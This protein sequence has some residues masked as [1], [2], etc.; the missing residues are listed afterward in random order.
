MPGRSTRH[1]D[2]DAP[3]LTPPGD[4]NESYP[5]ASSPARHLPCDGGVT[6]PLFL[7]V[8]TTPR[9]ALGD[10]IGDGLSVH[11]NRLVV[12]IRVKVCARKNASTGGTRAGS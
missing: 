6:L 3:E 7:D 9:Y 5:T 8:P 1:T 11:I 4:P 2:A 10:R 12:V